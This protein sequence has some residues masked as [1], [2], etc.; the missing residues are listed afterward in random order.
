MRRARC[1]SVVAESDTARLTPVSAI[2]RG[3]TGT[4]PTVET[5]MRRGETEELP[6]AVG[7]VGDE[8][9]GE[10]AE[11]EVGVEPGAQPAREVRH[12]REVVRALAVHPGE[13]LRRAIARLARGRA[14][15]L[16]LAA[17]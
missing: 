6:R 17:R 16:E 3:I 10:A 15:R 8:D 9:G 1:A 14:P 2:R 12:A 11:R 13:D 4:R 5:V 7:G